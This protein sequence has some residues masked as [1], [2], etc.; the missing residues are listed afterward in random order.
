VT[1]ERWKRVESVFQAALDRASSD[2][3]R[4]VSEACAADHDLMLEVE[5]LLLAHEKAGGF[6]SGGVAGSASTSSDHT[7]SVARPTLDAGTRLG[8]YEVRSLLA[9]GGMGE[10]YVARDE[11]LG[12]E[13]AVKVLPRTWQADTGRLR[14]FQQEA[15]AVGALNHPHILAVYDLGEANGL[16][17]VVSELLEGETLRVRLGRGALPVP[18]ALTLARQ[19]ATGLVAAHEK[20]I[21]HRDLKPSNLFLT[22]DGR[23]KILDFGLAKQAA[24]ALPSSV[25][26]EPGVVLGTVGYM[27]PE[28]VRGEGGDHRSDLFAFGAVVYEMLSGRRAFGAGAA[29][30]VMAAILREEPDLAAL[31]PEAPTAFSALL[32]RCLRKDAAQRPTS[33]HEVLSALDEAARQHAAGERAGRRRAVAV[34]PFRSL[35]P[36]A[37]ASQL[38]LGLADAAITELAQLRSLVVRPTSAVL[39]W[40]D[41]PYAPDEVVRELGVEAVVDGTLQQAGG[42]L[43]VTVQL[44]DA[45][46]RAIW[47]S[48]FDGAADDLFRLQ[49]DVAREVA[50]ALELELTPAD[51]RRL[52]RHRQERAVSGDAYAYYLKG[53]AH[54]FRE[55]LDECIAAV[56]LFEKAR[57]ANPSF[58]LAWA[59]LADNYVRI[60]FEFQPEGDWYARAETACARALAIDPQLPEARY[61]RARLLWSPHGGF[62]HAGGLRE[63]AAALA[64][65]PNLEEAWLRVGVQLWHVGSLAEAEQTLAR[66]LA[67]SP[68]HMIARGHVASCRYHAGEYA[69]ALALIAP[70]LEQSRSYWHHYIAAHSLLRLDRRGETAAMAQRMQAYL[71]G[72]GHSHA[73]RGLLAALDGDASEA[74]R[75][76]GRTAEAKRGFGHYHHEQY[77]VACIYALLG[78][79][80]KGLRWLE[81]AA[82]NGYPCFPFFEHDPLLAGL[83]S[84]GGFKPL[85]DRMKAECAGYARL[86]TQLREGLSST[87]A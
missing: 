21:V 53:K 40:R 78:R 66:A 41:Q 9:A 83:R 74:E 29:A 39:R 42:R 48:K 67:L 64:G 54:Q 77:D 55:S 68:E 71:E 35:V 37:E 2:R 51:E 62:D 65:R 73:V 8:P 84:Q 86:W 16:P 36:D 20:G 23:L 1:P 63:L 57:E 22:A 46:G 10:V 44:V 18:E 31:P 34:M 70:V 76:I 26:T 6:I 30:E 49:D 72:I 58:A 79:P 75:C 52:H 61:V 69:Q 28:Q 7:A 17:Y 47:A 87:G 4:F 43:R 11:R 12:R 13:V 45:D 81:E 3:E 85:V 5:S 80:E 59:G 56:D 38:G 32:R 25:A 15:R 60:A 19:L 50:R 14:R 33:A 24:P 82:R 27:A